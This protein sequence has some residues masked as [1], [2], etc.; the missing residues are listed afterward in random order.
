MM[1]TK[2]IENHHLIALSPSQISTPVSIHF[3]QQKIN[4]YRHRLQ[5]VMAARG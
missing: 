2:N 1:N 5:A 4:S 3:C